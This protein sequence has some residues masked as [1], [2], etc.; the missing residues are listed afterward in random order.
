MRDI[1]CA[2][3]AVAMLFTAN[4]P[5]LAQAHAPARPDA[6]AYLRC[7]GMTAHRSTGELLGRA[8]LL[9]ATMGIAGKGENNDASKRAYG[10]DGV[11]A[12]DLAISSETDTMRKIQLVQARAIHRIELGDYNLALQDL[13]STPSLAGPEAGD[14]SFRHTL[15][16]SALE[17]EAAA[18]L[19]A[20]QPAEAEAAA[21]RMA[22]AAPYE[23]YAQIRAA[24]YAQLTAELTPAKRVFLDRLVKLSPEAFALRAGIHEWA[25]QYLEAAADY[26]TLIE[27]SAAYAA[28]GEAPPMPSTQALRSVALAMGGRMAESAS[29][30]AEAAAMIRV[31]TATGKAG[32]MKASLD[33]AEQALDF[34]A[35]VQDLTEGRAAMARTKFSARSRWPVPSA[36]VVADLA[37]RLRQG[38]PAAELT[39]ILAQDPAKMRADALAANAGA[40]TQAQDAVPSLYGVVRKPLTPANYR[41]WDSDV[42]NA[43]DSTLLHKRAAGETY[44]GE[45]L[46]VD[47][48]RSILVASRHLITIAAGEALLLHA[49][50][51]AQARGVKG[52]LLFPSRQQMAAFLVKFGDPGSP[53]MPAAATFDAATVIADLSGEFPDPSVKP[54]AS[55]ATP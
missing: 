37:A 27:L 55:S 40:I 3:L 34:R 28:G 15:L 29:V 21:M 46:M 35:I 36:P 5:A 4:A 22:E 33:N 25:G 30:A 26:A 31:L 10:L 49:A 11:E 54:A 14:A 53:G 7:D 48:S 50:V 47:N 39:G 8:L 9:G 12:C 17:L 38:A 41:D 13:R 18:L 52:F 20:G 6:S 43:R 16:V 51:L 45:L 1:I 42:W 23:I 32:L 44:P 19:R 2:S 24:N